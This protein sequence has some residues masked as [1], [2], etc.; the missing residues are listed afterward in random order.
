LHIISFLKKREDLKVDI[1][2]NI[3][4]GL[5]FICTVFTFSADAKS[6]EKSDDCV[7]AENN[8]GLDVFA[9]SALMQVGSGAVFDVQ[10]ISE[11]GLHDDL[12]YL[13][14][15]GLVRLREVQDAGKS[16]LAVAMSETGRDALKKLMDY[17]KKSDNCF[18]KSR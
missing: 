12:L 13:S 4:L 6:V 10:D 16:W 2:T 5:L 17:R 11:S 7:C 14:L 15:K 9:L 3:V 1:K 18:R 8:L